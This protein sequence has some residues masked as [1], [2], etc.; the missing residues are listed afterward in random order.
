MIRVVH[1]G[2]RSCFLPISDPGSGSF[3]YPSRIPDPEVKKDPDPQH[4]T[5]VNVSYWDDNPTPF[6]GIN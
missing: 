2:Y 3:F 5:Q 4:C 1:P 6:V